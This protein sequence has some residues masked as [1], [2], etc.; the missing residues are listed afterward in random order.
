M[1]E[2]RSHRVSQKHFQLGGFRCLALTLYARKEVIES[3]RGGVNLDLDHCGTPGHQKNTY[4]TRQKSLRTF[5]F[6]WKNHK[7]FTHVVH[8]ETFKHSL[9]VLS[10]GSNTMSSISTMH[11]P[12]WRSP[13]LQISVTL[14]PT[15]GD[16]IVTGTTSYAQRS[17]WKN[18]LNQLGPSMV[19][20]PVFVTSRLKIKWTALMVL[21][22]KS[23]WYHTYVM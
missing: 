23:C 1:L 8:C 13:I 16:L 9:I 2:T 14:R 18:T 5:L 11:L 12:S 6:T 15:H 19:N 20:A 10:L 3:K 21:R 22:N 4:H 7:F 17:T